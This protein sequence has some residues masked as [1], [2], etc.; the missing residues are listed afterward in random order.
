MSGGDLRLGFVRLG[1]SHAALVHHLRINAALLHQLQMRPAL[2]DDTAVDNS[3]AV[4]R[5][6]CLET[7]CNE[8][9]R[10]ACGNAEAA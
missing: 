10:R 4:G 7:M 3:N 8:N 5:L 1:V 2:D 6:D 9:R